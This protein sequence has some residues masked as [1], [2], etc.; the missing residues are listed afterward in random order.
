MEAVEGFESPEEL[1][2]TVDGG[3]G[4]ETEEERKK[5]ELEKNRINTRLKSQQHIIHPNKAMFKFGDV[6]PQYLTI[7]L[8]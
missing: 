6:S 7:Y 5:E 4:E 8:Q 1:W 3:D 2:C